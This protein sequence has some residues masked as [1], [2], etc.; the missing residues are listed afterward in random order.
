MSS[1]SKA[2]ELCA[3]AEKKLTSF[4]GGLFGN[5]YEDALE[6]YKQAANIYK[7]NK[8]FKEAA[9]C[10]IK[11]AELNTQNDSK[12]QAG[13]C[14]NDAANCYRQLKDFENVVNCLKSCSE[15]YVKLG[16]FSNAAKIYKDIAETYEK[17]QKN[18][19]EAA[20]YYRQAAELFDGE[21]SKS[22]ATSSYARQAELLLLSKQYDEAIKVFEK[23]AERSVDEKL[24]TFGVKDYLY[25]GILC[26][27]GRLKFENLHDGLEEIKNAL[28]K[29]KDMDMKFMD[30]RECKLC[31]KVLEC[32]EKQEFS[33]F[34]KTVKEYDKI[35]RLENWELSTLTV[36]K[37]NLKKL[38]Q[39]VDIE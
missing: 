9:E 10:F 7:N 32:F 26:R 28:D 11:C 8:S 2:K 39:S 24:L 13:N 20:E 30:T 31:E 21:N 6:L 18:F 22:T 38:I 14:Y 37:E 3:Q 34:E 19:T 27:F 5:K 35:S 17:E 36:A 12:F 15:V 1:D 16:K 25:K 4:L 29:Y 33:T 23:C